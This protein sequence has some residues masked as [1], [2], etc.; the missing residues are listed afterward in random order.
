LPFF[1]DLYGTAEL[2]SPL[3]LPPALAV[4]SAPS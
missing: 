2:K 3:D 4:R 1:L